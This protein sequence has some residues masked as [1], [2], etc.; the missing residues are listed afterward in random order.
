MKK[1]I[2]IAISAILISTT[3]CSRA[4]QEDVSTSEEVVQKG[5]YNIL[6]T[7]DFLA[8]KL[9]DGSFEELPNGNWIDFRVEKR[10]FPVFNMSLFGEKRKGGF[11][12]DGNDLVTALIVSGENA[13]FEVSM[14]IVSIKDNEAICEGWIGK[15]NENKH[16]FKLRRR[17]E[18]K[19]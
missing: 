1:N 4:S 12:Y 13:P 19:N 15:N 16:T 14:R 18:S 3:S 9:E 6:G 17:G 2:L 11:V 7:W 5:K 8:E 10:I